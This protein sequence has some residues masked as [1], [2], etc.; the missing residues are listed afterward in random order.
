M[1]VVGHSDTG[2]TT[3]VSALL[4][5]SG[6]VNRLCKVDDGNTITDFDEDEIERKITINTAV[7]HFDHRGT[8][9]NLI[10]TPGYG[11][12][13]TEAVQGL[14]VADAALLM[15][16]AV[17]GIEVQTEKL[18]KAAADFELPVLF[19]VNLMDR[20]R[21][22][23]E[24]TARG[25]A[26]EV[27]PRGGARSSCRSARRAAFRGVVDLHHRQGLH[28]AARRERQRLTEVD[29]PADLA[30]AGGGCPRGA[31]GDGGRAGRGADGGL[32]R[33]R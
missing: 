27:R 14:R 28:L 22:S 26:E 9:V 20:D 15:I 33:G 12:Y 2:K 24:R 31:D 13:T 32:P 7:A 5:D 10:D 3:L 4:F 8:K 16:S 6:V 17:A 19:G 29:V 23:F 25:A 1:A 18:W 11:I 30:D 21:A